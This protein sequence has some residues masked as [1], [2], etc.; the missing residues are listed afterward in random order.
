M[1]VT[2]TATARNPRSHFTM[3]CKAQR[4][5]EVRSAK[6]VLLWQVCVHVCAC[7]SARVCVHVGVSLLGG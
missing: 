6:R 2:I 5:L 1:A 3:V 7:V 4:E